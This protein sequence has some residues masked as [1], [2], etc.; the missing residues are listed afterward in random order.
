MALALGGAEDGEAAPQR[1][2]EGRGRGCGSESSVSGA[3]V[4]RDVKPSALR[5]EL[6]GGLLLGRHGQRAHCRANELRVLRVERGKVG[7]RVRD[8]GGELLA[9]HMRSKGAQMQ[10]SL[11]RAA[12]L[13]ELVAVNSAPL[14][15]GGRI[16][17]T[18][19][20]K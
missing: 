16:L 18:Q 4:T 3:H 17:G 8:R 14:E 9:S 7:A 19:R 6:V 2:H 12:E 13:L 1:E 15:R 20:C 11:E 10:Q 5:E